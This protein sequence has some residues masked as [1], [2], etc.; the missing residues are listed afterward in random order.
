MQFISALNARPTGRSGAI[1]LGVLQVPV[2][3]EAIE[4]KSYFYHIDYDRSLVTSIFLSGIILTI[5]RDISTEDC[6]AR[7]K[8]LEMNGE[9]SWVVQCGAC[10]TLA[11][12]FLFE[13]R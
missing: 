1:C 3:I 11:L 2:S 9:L 6:T 13:A 7:Q 8:R 10:V 4:T 12:P 5:M